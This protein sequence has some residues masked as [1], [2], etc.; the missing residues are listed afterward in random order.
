[1]KAELGTQRRRTLASRKG[2]EVQSSDSEGE[3]PDQT[4]DEI[5][6]N[7]DES[8]DDDAE[9]EKLVAMFAK[10]VKKIASRNFR[11]NNIKRRFDQK[12]KEAFRKKDGKD[13]K[14]KTL[15]KSKVKCYNCDKL[16]HYA[17]ECRNKGKALITSTKNWMNSS[18]SEEEVN[19][20]LMSKMETPE[21]VIHPV[22]NIDIDDISELKR[23]PKHQ[24]LDFKNQS[25]E[26]AR[27]KYE[28]SALKE[29]NCQ[30]ESELKSM[31]EIQ[32]KH[33]QTIVRKDALE[34]RNQKLEEKLKETEGLI[35]R[36]HRSGKKLDGLMGNEEAIY[37]IGFKEKSENNVTSKF[38]DSFKKIEY[39]MKPLP[40]CEVEKKTK[41][42][43][44]SEKSKI[45][46]KEE[47]KLKT[48]RMNDLPKIGLLK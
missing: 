1:L 7:T 35:K 47:Q 14:A 29:R 25:Q 17:T 18:E 24:H 23:Y 21:K 48:S 15:D 40:G 38:D 16:G 11:R 5:F 8:P 19:Y 22:F 30:V 45:K 12:D 28:I 3:S 4:P 32:K 26:N 37:G 34:I 20:A 31:N 33:D 6:D 36:W 41:F 39:E 42:V 9:M 44:S 10:G 13:L 27:L 46:E 2:K 43:L